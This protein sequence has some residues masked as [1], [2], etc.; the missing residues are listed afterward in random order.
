MIVDDLWA[1]VGSTNFDHRSFRI[2]DE[3]NLAMQDA[4]IATRLT[5]DFFR[6][7]EQSSRVTYDEWRRYRSARLLDWLGSLIER[8]E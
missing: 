5:Q 8:Q 4:G 6:D 1:V 7:L 2:N 3:V